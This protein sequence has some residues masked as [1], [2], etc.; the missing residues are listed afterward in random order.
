MS[1]KKLNTLKKNR[2]FGYVYRRGNAVRTKCFTMIFV[3]SRYGGIR[4][5]FQASK[6][7]GNSVV[8]NRARRRMK[9]ACR[10][11]FDDLNGNY[12]I[13]FVLKPSIADAGYADILNSITASLEKARIIGKGRK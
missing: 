7:I 6:K 3:K 5:G 2:E 8:R 12:S 1:A 9:E 10:A 13:V 11:V 4:A